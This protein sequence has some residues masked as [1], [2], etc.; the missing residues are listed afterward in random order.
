MQIVL[1]VE[2]QGHPAPAAAAADAGLHAQAA[3]DLPRQVLVDQGGGLLFGRLFTGLFRLFRFQPLRLFLGLAH[4]QALLDHG[5]DQQQSA[6][7]KDRPCDRIIG[8]DDQNKVSLLLEHAGVYRDVA[9]PWYT[10]NFQATWDDVNL[11]CRALLDE[12]LSD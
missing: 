4:G 6:A 7:A 12:I 11:G 5:G 1:A 2:I 3:G 9:D 10:G 8:E